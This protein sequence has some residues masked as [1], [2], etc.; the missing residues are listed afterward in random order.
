LIVSLG[1]LYVAV[2]GLLGK[3]AGFNELK[4]GE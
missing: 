2:V 4:D 3:F 1:I